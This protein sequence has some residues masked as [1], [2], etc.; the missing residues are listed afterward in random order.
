MAKSQGM[1]I[2]WI[3]GLP[4]YKLEN[5]FI[6]SPIELN[7]IIISNDPEIREST[8]LGENFSFLVCCRKNIDYIKVLLLK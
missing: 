4:F 5:P 7:W 1:H 8:K 2:Y 6:I 3:L